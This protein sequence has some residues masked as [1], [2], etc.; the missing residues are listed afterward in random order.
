MPYIK[1]EDRVKY[2]KILSNMPKI[3]SEGELNYLISTLIIKFMAGYVNYTTINKSIGALECAKL[4]LYR[5]VASPYEDIK[6]EENGG[7]I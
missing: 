1:Q 4:E 5:M 3:E 7:I 6:H 2:S